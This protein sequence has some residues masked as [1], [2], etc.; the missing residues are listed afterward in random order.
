[1]DARRPFRTRETRRR[2]WGPQASGIPPLS[3]RPRYAIERARC[4]SRSPSGRVKSRPDSI[5]RTCERSPAV[6]STWRRVAIAIPLLQLPAVL[7]VVDLLTTGPGDL[8]LPHTW[9]SLG[10]RFQPRHCLRRTWL[11]RL[12]TMRREIQQA[13]YGHL[14]LSVNVNSAKARGLLVRYSRERNP[15]G[16]SAADKVCRKDRVVS[17]KR[18]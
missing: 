6:S 1:M 12:A 7:D 4:R 13:N 10:T 14:A 18:S 11:L 17:G 8:T 16:R 3:R 15:E 2:A 9:R 5:L